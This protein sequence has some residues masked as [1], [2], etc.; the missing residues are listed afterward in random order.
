M[1]NPYSPP[2]PLTEANPEAAPSF[3][4]RAAAGLGWQQ[5][6]AHFLLTTGVTLVWTLLMLVAANSCIGLIVLPHLA[7]G[8]AIAGIAVARN[9]PRFEAMFSSFESFGPVLAAGG[10]FALLYSVGFVL[11]FAVL[12]GMIF[13]IT[14][15]SEA[16][17][18]K[19]FGALVDN[20][21]SSDASGY[22]G[23]ST[24]GIGLLLLVFLS[25]RFQLAF[26]LVMERKLPAIE[27]FK[28]SWRITSSHSI[29]LGTFKLTFDLL[30]PTFGL[31]LGCFPGILFAM[32]LG[33]AMRGA[34][35]SMLLGET[36]V[37]AAP[38]NTTLV[39]TPA[40]APAPEQYDSQQRSPWSQGSV[41]QG[42]SWSP[43]QST[44][45]K[46]DE[47]NPYN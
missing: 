7:A 27:A 14:F 43:A 38:A 15:W 10:L 40:T 26:N 29:S 42:G 45:T 39:D 31:M 13:L 24:M 28:E 46:R 37:V 5:Y 17:G 44:P 23:L 30:L 41:Q 3:S 16:L 1:D 18:W 36:P 22:L 2:E 33:L 35:S 8:W 4:L 11:V 20:E 21:N 9:K 47:S 12:L 32:P 6:K 25:A 19:Q 34:A